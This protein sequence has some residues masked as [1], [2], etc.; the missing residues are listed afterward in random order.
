MAE[1]YF[2]VI[3]A[4][5]GDEGKGA[6]VDYLA[7]KYRAGEV[8]VIRYN[9]GAQAGHTVQLANGTRHVFSHF[10]A[11]TFAGARTVLAREFVCNP[12]LFRREREEL[13][14]KKFIPMFPYTDPRCKITT[15]YDMLANQI[16]ESERQKTN[17]HHGSVGVGFNATIQR[18]LDLD[19][20]FLDCTDL[21]LKNQLQRIKS[22][23][24]IRLKHE[25][26][27]IPDS[28]VEI[29]HSYKNLFAKFKEDLEYFRDHTCLKEDIH[30]KDCDTVIF[31][32]AQ[33]L[34]LDRGAAGYPHLTNSHTGLQ[35]IMTLY[36]RTPDLGGRHI[37][38]AYYVT[39]PYVTRHGAGP[40]FYPLPT[41]QLPSPL[42]SDPTNVANTFQGAPRFAKLDIRQFVDTVSCTSMRRYSH[43]MLGAVSCLDHI[44]VNGQEIITNY[45]G[46]IIVDSSS[47]TRRIRDVFGSGEVLTN[48]GP[49]RETIGEV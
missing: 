18:D 23:H 34:L 17:T 43:N 27:K 26:G 15:P 3:G 44:S 7:H 10:G 40:L 28:W 38:K 9:G 41:G 19:F 45:S 49:T 30:F 29:W 32:G 16:A 12:L 35:N 24:E 48:A 8:N 33:G 11:G 20:N 31:E 4:H 6:F 36:D 5:Y 46:P 14:S 22:W 37:T 1:N 2:A 13:V 47:L 42:Y 39:R 21:S 25:F